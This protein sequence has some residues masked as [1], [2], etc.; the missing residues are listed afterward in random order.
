MNLADRIQNLRKAKGLSQEELAEALGV[1]RQAV[2]KW[3]SSQSSPDLDKII[4]LS[5]YFNV[6]TDHL[7]KGT[8]LPEA[9]SDGLDTAFIFNAVATA[10]DL[11]SIVLSA[12]IWYET[13]EAGALIV[14]F[15]FIVF[16][17]MLH[18]IGSRWARGRAGLT[19]R[20]RFWK[21]NIWPVLFL[22][23]SLSYN[24]LALNWPAPY[25]LVAMNRLIP[26]ALFWIIYLGVGTAVTLGC[27]KKE[28]AIK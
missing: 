3:E 1:S 13:Q 2:S 23:L 27:V 10:F 8:E 16:G 25:P 18:V 24:I 20:L 17:L 9:G 11:L 7:L 14:G 19:L 6:S 28:R 15:I 22:P 4:Q 12:F 26:F 5:E 21:I